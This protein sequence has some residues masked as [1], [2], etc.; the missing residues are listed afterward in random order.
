MPSFRV[1]YMKD[2]KGLARYIE[3]RIVLSALDGVRIRH[4]GNSMVIIIGGYMRRNGRRYCQILQQIS[5]SLADFILTSHE[6]DILSRIIGRICEGLP[7]SELEEIGRIACKRLYPENA[8]EEYINQRRK[9]ISDKIS[10]YLRT[11]SSLTLDGF[12]TFR[13]GEYVK[14]LEAEVEKALREY[15]VEKQYEEY[16]NLLSA[17]IRM[18]CPRV[19]ELH[20]FALGDGSYR[21]EGTKPFEIP[22][23]IKR[24]Y[25][26]EKGRPIIRDDD[27][28][29]GFLL[30]CA[31]IR[32]F[33]HNADKFKNKELLN[34]IKT[35][36][37]ECI[38]VND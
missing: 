18:Q 20:V 27:F 26:M 5:D 28:M 11:S 8:A 1:D 12:I 30:T 25:G 9:L 37:S 19:P 24:S 23:D 13:L 31:P 7:R 3:K 21:V 36:F 34:T 17:F 15:F 33:I 2:I 6:K 32:I 4:E 29:I 16:I 14:E 22:E 35:V 38:L 10:E